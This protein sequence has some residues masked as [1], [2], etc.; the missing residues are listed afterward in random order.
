M[1]HF[2]FILALVAVVLSVSSL[3]GENYQYLTD[4]E[5]N[6]MF[7]GDIIRFFGRDTIWGDHRTNG[8]FH[9]QNV[10]GWPT[11]YGHVY[12]SCDTPEWTGPWPIPANVFFNAPQLE[13]PDSLDIIRASQQTATFSIPGDEWHA[14]IRGGLLILYHYPEGTFF[15]SLSAQSISVSLSRAVIFVDGL[16]DIEG[17]MSPNEC[18]LILAC[19]QDIR[20]I[21]NVMLEGTNL[22]SGELPVG[23][24]SRIAIASERGIYIA[25]TIA[26]GRNNCSN[27]GHSNP[28]HAACHIVIT[29][30][31]TALGTGFQMEDM[32]DVDDPYQ[33]PSPDERGNIVL[34]GGLTQSY[35]GYVHRSNHGG[36]GYNKVYHWDQRMDDWRIGVFEPFEDHQ[37]EFTD[38][39]DFLLPERI[40]V[41][42]AP[43]PFNATTTIR[44]SLPNSEMVSARVFD[45]QG[46]EVATLTN[47]TFSAGEHTLQFDGT[48]FASG[49]YFLSF[50][51]KNTISTQKLL[52]LK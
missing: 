35:R 14:S 44:F 42:I 26:N 1:K 52:L 37:N 31:L 4:H 5:Y 45:I 33:G 2:A 29:A 46:R 25:N 10:G 38:A 15:D 3:R 51:A 6:W 21:D 24:T 34:T 13:F 30:Y 12:M 16:L 23:A 48:A 7:P 9:F 39:D 49:V 17:E 50:K 40:S 43:N 20:L 11:V 32:N 36:T 22:T 18:E 28:N 41:N 8:C 47:K 27:G 19:S